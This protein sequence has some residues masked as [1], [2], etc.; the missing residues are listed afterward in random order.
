MTE[1]NE[2]PIAIVNPTGVEIGGTQ[3]YET[4]NVVPV[5]IVN[6]DGSIIGS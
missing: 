4:Q 3:Q 2:L 5:A 6:L 1:Q